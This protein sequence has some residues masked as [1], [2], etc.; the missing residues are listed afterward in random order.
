M[1]NHTGKTV[2]LS[3]FL[4]WVMNMTMDMFMSVMF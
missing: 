2:N 1:A 3:A 4:F